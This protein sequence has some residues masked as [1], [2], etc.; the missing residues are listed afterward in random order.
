MHVLVAFVAAALLLTP[1][2]GEDVRAQLTVTER[3]GVVRDVRLRI[4]RLG[5]VRLDTK[6]PRLGCAD[7]P[8][9]RVVGRPV[10]RDLDRDGESEVVVDV[11][12]GGA[13]CCTHSLLYRWQPRGRRYVRSTAGWG[14]QGYR[15]ADLNADRR[16]ELSSR[17][18]RFA[19]RF[20]A[21]AASAS[22][23]RIWH[24]DRG[25]LRDVTRRFP[26]AVE[27]DAA[28]LWQD[29]LRVR[30]NE[31]REVRGLLAAWLADQALLGH[32]DQGWRRLEQAHRRGELGRGARVD[33]YHA[34]RGYLAELRSFLRRAG[35]VR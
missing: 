1:A 22:P 24:Y 14:N 11:Y 21:Y 29:Y 19:A 10:V 20:T 16:P 28:L 30:R 31:V 3:A 9:W 6:V 13:H 35:Y 12:T 27:R 18:D 32:A 34:G 23:L 33:G 26:R 5:R 7:C 2:A 17:D 25:R 8:G 15:L 4:V